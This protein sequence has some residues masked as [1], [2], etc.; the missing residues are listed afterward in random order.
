[1]KLIIA[2]ADEQTEAK[3]K[4]ILRKNGN[5]LEA[6]CRKTDILIDYV[7][8]LRPDMIIMDLELTGKFKTA[9]VTKYFNEVYNIPV[10]Y[11]I[12]NSAHVKIMNALETNPFG[13]ITDPDDD[14]QV[15]FTLELVYNKFSESLHLL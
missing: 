10:V 1:M 8:I 6:V 11:L 14:R 4:E 12:N 9:E 3:L 2:V 15:N 5:E 13:L 7:E